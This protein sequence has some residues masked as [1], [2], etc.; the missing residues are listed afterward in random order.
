M[1]C[2]VTQYFDVH[3][4]VP[5]RIQIADLRA[6]LSRSEQQASWR[7]DQLRQEITTLQSVRLSCSCDDNR[8]NVCAHT[9]SDCAVHHVCAHDP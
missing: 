9:M 1:S 3:R 2:C 5:F 8:Y 6:G 7:E 4:M